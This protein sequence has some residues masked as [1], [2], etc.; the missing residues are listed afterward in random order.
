MPSNPTIVVYGSADGVNLV[1]ASQVSLNG[2]RVNAWFPS[3]NIRYL[4]IR[5]TPAMPDTLG[6]STYTFGITSVS[7]FGELLPVF[8]DRLEAG[9]V[10]AGGRQGPVQ[11]QRPHAGLLPAVSAKAASSRW[12]RTR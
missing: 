12:R 4:Q 2:Y 7:A 10:P 8:R 6:G 1:Q 11:D 3:K 9:G 5:I